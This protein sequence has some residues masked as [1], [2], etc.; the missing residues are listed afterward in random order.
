MKSAIMLVDDEPECQTVMATMLGRRGFEV[1]VAGGAEEALE[2]I[3]KA[4]LDAV[5]TDVMLLGTNGIE[6]CKRLSE[7]RPELP[8]IVATAHSSLDIAVEAIRAGAYDFIT[9]P[10]AAEAFA[11]AIER[12]VRH[13]RLTAEIRRLREDSAAPRTPATIVGDSP[14]VRKVN[15]LIDQVASSMATVLVNGESGTGK[16]LVA[17]ALHER[18]GRAGKPFVAV[19]CAAMPATLLESELFGHARGAFTDAKRARNGLFAQAGEGTLFL[20]EIGEI[21]QETQVKLLRVLQE[22]KLRPIGSDVEVPFA[23][24]LVVATNRDLQAEVEAGRFRADLFY[25]INVVKLD[26][27]ALRE[28][29]GDVLLLAHHFLARYA[30]QSRKAVVGISAP[31]ARKL[32]DYTWPGN[33]RELENSLQ[34]AVAL[35]RYSEITIEDLPEP[36]QAYQPPQVMDG[37]PE[38]LPS[39]DEMQRRYIKKV[40]AACH[41]NKTQAAKVLGIYRRALYRRMAQLGLDTGGKLGGADAVLDEAAQAEADRL[42]ELAGE[43]D[44]EAAP[45]GGAH[46]HEHAA[47]VA[48]VAG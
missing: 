38:E 19:N 27:P 14:A 31:A 12:A 5:V 25:R 45:A 41:G 16:E 48:A 3:G 23:A 1:I 8:V 40:L 2:R 9:K 11:L 24:R 43:D 34:R 44:D 35:A 28:R 30:K 29:H 36:I 32:M 37:R 26:V 22:R 4:E 21:P 47:P 18:G 17:R 15:E 42:A 46:A 20:D 6:L 33:I 39:L 10:L 7:L 13:R